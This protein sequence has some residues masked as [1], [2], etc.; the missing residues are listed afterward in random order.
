M[1]AVKTLSIKAVNGLFDKKNWEDTSLS[2][3][4][5]KIRLYPGIINQ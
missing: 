2:E 3:D 4:L 1:S 5:T